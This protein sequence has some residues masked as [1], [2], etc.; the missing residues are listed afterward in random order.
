MACILESTEIK[1]LWPIFNYS[2]KRWEDV[3][4]IFSYEDQNGYLRLAIEKN[5]KYISPVYTFH[6]LVDGH[7]VL[8]KLINEFNLC[9]KLCFLQ[10]DNEPCSAMAEEKCFGACERKEKPKRYNKRVMQAIQSLSVQ[11]SYAIIDKGLKE[12]EQSCVL[13]CNGQFYGMGYVPSDTPVT[14][15]QQLKNFIAPYKENSFIRNLVSGYAA[16]FPSK[17]IS[18]SNE[19]FQSSH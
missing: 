12:D 10:T 13:V 8:R 16:R 11:P 7:A 14:D 19:I 15:P 5:K 4:G 9:P 1:K 18:F 17:I 3:Y 2:Q 6:Y